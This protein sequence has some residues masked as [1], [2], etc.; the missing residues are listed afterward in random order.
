MGPKWA[1]E[2]QP[3]GAPGFFSSVGTVSLPVGQRVRAE[4]LA[5]YYIDF[6]RKARAPE[7]PPRWH[8]PPADELFVATIQWGLGAYERFVAGEGE[9]WLAGALGA[10]EHLVASQ[11]DGGAHDGGWVHD[12]PTQHT[13]VLEPPW[14]S[15]MAQ[16]EGASL[17]ARLYA[18]TGEERF[19]EASLRALRPLQVATENGG[20][21]VPLGSGFFLEEY[22]TDPPS[23]VLNGA[24]FALWGY[25][26]VAIALGDRQAADQFE[27]GVE[28]L[29]AN[30]HRWDTGSWSRYDLFPHPVANVASSFY[31]DLHINQIRAMQLIAPRPELDAAEARFERYRASRRRRLAALARKAA[32]RILVPRNRLL[33]GW[34][35]FG[36]RRPR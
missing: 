7:W 31:H 24:F 3:K 2:R 5:G 25:R 35:F 11:R 29:A 12:A 20:V 30:L 9:Q 14:I 4:G 21:R 19:A 10:A 26:D 18:E 13:Y 27:A 17:L 23:L 6:A 8:G 36:P 34:F 22:P 33:A 28:S 32:F 15:G 16:G 1:W